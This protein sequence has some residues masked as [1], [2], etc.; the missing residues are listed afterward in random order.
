MKPLFTKEEFNS[1][2]SND[3]LQCECYVC[4]KSFGQLKK[5]IKSKYNKNKF[6]SKECYS[7]HRSY[8]LK[9]KCSNCENEFD[10]TPSEISK[11]KSGNHF[12]SKSCST[13]YNNKNKTHGT[14]RSKLERWLEEELTAI[15]PKLEVHYNKKD[16][17]NS[18]LDIYIPSLNLAVE[19]NGIFHYEP[20]FGEDKLRQI[21][22]ND[23]RKFQACLEEGIELA[24]VDAS[25]L[26]Y[27]KPK[28]AQK[29]LNII[30]D[31]ID[32]KSKNVLK[33]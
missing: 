19:L 26:K 13:T 4:K 22:N 15:Y 31:I 30:T 18:E 24:I 7:T 1:A 16:A 6:C 23:Q 29:Y 9:V 2:K 17:I 3:Y 28:K 5:H 14:R 27:F 10:K 8:K 20:I 12:C 32:N 25:Q 21:Q 33:S 11:S